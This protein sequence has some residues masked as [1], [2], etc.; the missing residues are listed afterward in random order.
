MAAQAL[1][2]RDV[3][4]VWRAPL[5]HMGMR[6]LAACVWLL[7]CTAQA[8]HRPQAVTTSA[9]FDT[10]PILPIPLTVDVDQR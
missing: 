4:I 5:R 3:P 1:M 9:P 8:D 2:D 6:L 10:E 7:A